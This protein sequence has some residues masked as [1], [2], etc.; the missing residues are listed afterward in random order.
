ML[1][2]A[3]VASSQ[4]SSLGL[5]RKARAMATLRCNGMIH[6]LVLICSPCVCSQLMRFHACAQS[7]QCC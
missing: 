4:I 3:E 5:R 1:T 2:K 6:N 7:L